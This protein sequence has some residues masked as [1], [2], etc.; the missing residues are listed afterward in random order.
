MFIHAGMTRPADALTIGDWRVFH[1]GVDD[2]YDEVQHYAEG[3]EGA[4]TSPLTLR[5]GAIVATAVLTHS[6]PVTD[7][8]PTSRIG[9]VAGA[10]T[11]DGTEYL[12]YHERGANSEWWHHPISDQYPLGRWVAPDGGRIRRWAWFLADIQPLPHPIPVAG[13]QGWWQHPV[14][15]QGGQVTPGIYLV[16]ES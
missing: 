10:I 1:R 14:L 11:I 15:A 6:I 12:T 9:T 16:G 8:A 3:I 7:S 5:Y 13:K 2:G 4:P